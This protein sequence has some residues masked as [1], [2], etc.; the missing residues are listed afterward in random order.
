MLRSS[1]AAS[2]SRIPDS[3]SIPASR[4]IASPLPLTAGLG[5]SIARDDAGDAR[6]DQRLWRM[7]VCGRCESRV[8]GCVDGRAA[9]RSRRPAGARSLPRGRCRPRC[10]SLRRRL[11]SVFDDDGADHA[12]GLVSADAAAGRVRWRVECIARP[13]W[14][15]TDGIEG[16]D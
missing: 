16:I 1:R 14:M 6:V 10:R 7:E 12:P 4:S 15:V 9:R 11:A 5:S 8:R 3:T 13:L 2:S